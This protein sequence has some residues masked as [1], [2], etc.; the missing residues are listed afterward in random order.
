MRLAVR[1][2]STAP[3]GVHA[4]EFAS[5]N[6]NIGV[7][8]RHAISDATGDASVP[9]DTMAGSLL[10]DTDLDEDGIG[11]GW[12]TIHFGDT[13]ISDG[14]GDADSDGVSDSDEFAL[15]TN[16][17]LSDSD[18]DGFKDSD[19]IIAGTGPAERRAKARFIVET[20]SVIDNAWRTSRAK[21]TQAT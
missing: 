11:D 4:V 1:A 2:D 13:T 17:S 21:K 6:P 9:Q 8:S 19:E 16:P 14:P 20:A 15:G 10:I 3:L 5:G 18:N 7:N 12:E